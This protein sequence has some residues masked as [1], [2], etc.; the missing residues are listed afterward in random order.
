MPSPMPGDIAGYAITSKNTPKIAASPTT[1]MI[2]CAFIGSGLPWSFS[3]IKQ[4]E[5]ST[6]NDGDWQEVYDGQVG[7]C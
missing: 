4:D 6:I 2:F 7:L 5:L 3:R 1:W